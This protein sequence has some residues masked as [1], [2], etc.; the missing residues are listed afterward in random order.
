MLLI[1]HIDTN[2]FVDDTFV[3]IR[4]KSYIPGHI[5]P[6]QV[7]ALASP[8]LTAPTGPAAYGALGARN[9]YEGVP[10]QSRKRSYNDRQEEKG[11]YDPH[12]GRGDR[13]MKQMRRGNLS[14]GRGGSSHVQHE[15]D[16]QLPNNPPG[17]TP[18]LSNGCPGLPMPAN[19]MPLDPIGPLLAMPAIHPLPPMPDLSQAASPGAFASWMGQLPLL[20]AS[21]GKS[22]INV[23]CRDYDTKGVCARGSACPFD[24]GNNQI[25]VPRQHEG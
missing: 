17:L 1:Q 18:S 23:R 7:S 5:P 20:E 14:N 6:Q 13:Q 15:R 3:A 16:Y 19:G 10:P 9:V 24:H 12:Y 2:A 21:V 8:T 22:K 4:T 25:I 11:G